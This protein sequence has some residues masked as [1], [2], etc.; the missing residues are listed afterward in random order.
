MTIIIDGN[1]TGTAGGASYGTGTSNNFTA[2][3]TTGQV[4]TSQGA[5]A[6][7]W[8][9]PSSGALVLLATL[10]PTAAT[11]VESLNVFTSAY[12]NYLILIQGIQTASATGTCTLDMR[13]A[14]AGAVDSNTRYRA[15]SGSSAAGVTFLN[16][17]ANVQL[18]IG[19]LD[20]TGPGLNASI[21]L[22]NTNATNSS[23]KT[24]FCSVFCN[25]AGVS[26]TLD[27]AS[28]YIGYNGTSALSGISF[29]LRN[30]ANFAAQG[31]VR[32][33]GYS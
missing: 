27:F 26:N 11:T 9:T 1:N 19:T 4:L 3:G 29:F 2:A 22:Q 20:V 12:D 25:P 17:Y 16:T 6:P 23:Y 33:Y 5:S 13:F 18:S 7:T 15:N 30:G 10:T 32:I 31:K 14:V 8:T 21:A 24:A 28:G